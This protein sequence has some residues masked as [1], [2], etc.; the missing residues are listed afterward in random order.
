MQMLIIAVAFYVFTINILECHSIIF[1]IP[2]AASS[3]Y[4]SARPPSCHE[5]WIRSR[6]THHRIFQHQQYLLPKNDL[7][8]L[9]AGCNDC[10]QSDSQE[11]SRSTGEVVGATGRIGSFLLESGGYLVPVPRDVQ[12]GSL[13]DQGCPIFVSVPTFQISNVIQRTLPARRNDLV[14]VTNGIPSDFLGLDDDNDNF[15]D[16]N[17][18]TTSVPYFGVLGVGEEVI[19]NELSPNTIINNGRHAKTLADLLE[20]SNIGCEIVDGM[21]EVD[22]A[23]VQKLIWVSIMW[24]LCHDCEEGPITVA[25]VHEEKSGQVDQL[26]EE[27]VPAA[28]H[29]LEKYHHGVFKKGVGSIAEVKKH[30]EDYSFSMPISIP[31]RMKAIEEFKFRNGYLLSMQNSVPQTLH[32][33]LV[34]NVVG[35]IPEY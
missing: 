32:R 10:K 25:Q 11:V 12:P 16:E 4:I 20:S 9:N 26:L 22:A 14:F 3:R 17:E 5:P 2:A 13:T 6:H 21:K 33:K 29:L 24:L 18:I 8:M 35:Y 30:L 28:N 27:L 19:T 15:I 23:A 1:S 31:A 7:C 34:R